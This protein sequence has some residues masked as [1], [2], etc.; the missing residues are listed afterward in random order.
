ML[1]DLAVLKA[2][3]VER[4]RRSGVTC[5]ALVSGMQ[6]D[7]IS[8]HKRAIGRYVGGG[9]IR[10]FSDKRFHPVKTVSDARVM[11]YE[12]LAEIAIDCCR[13]FL[14]K[15]VGHGLT[16]GNAQSVRCRHGSLLRLSRRRIPDSP[17]ATR[18]HGPQHDSSVSSE[19]PGRG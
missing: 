7:E 14:L 6:Q 18:N 11:L 10:C 8:V 4:N 12:R 15:D 16:S 13:I 5:D 17:N 2:E 19:V 9:R 1:N 3:Q